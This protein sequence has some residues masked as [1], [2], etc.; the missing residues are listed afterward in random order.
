MKK[1]ESVGRELLDMNIE[2][3]MARLGQWNYMIKLGK[4][5]MDRG[6]IVCNLGILLKT[7]NTEMHGSIAKNGNK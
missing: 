7:R 3:H 4:H 6:K 1:N 5:N 2:D